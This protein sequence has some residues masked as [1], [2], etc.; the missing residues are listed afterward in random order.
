M[1]AQYAMVLVD[2]NV[3]NQM[4]ICLMALI[5]LAKCVCWFM[6]QANGLP[7]FTLVISVWINQ[8]DTL[9]V[10]VDNHHR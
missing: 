1:Y 4:Y 6:I 7:S 3:L 9:Y 10:S 2:Q 5:I 8:V